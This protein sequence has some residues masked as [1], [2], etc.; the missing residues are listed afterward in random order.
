MA[1]VEGYVDD[2]GQALV[3]I[4]VGGSRGER[5]LKAV[6]DTGFSGDVSLPTSLA[7][8]LGLELWGAEMFELADGSRVEGLLFAGRLRLGEEEREVEVVL[9]N[10]PDALVGAGLLR[11][12][13]LEID[14]PSRQVI[15]R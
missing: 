5:V 15:I 10:S 3:E 1:V 4:G 12:K 6:V 13:R 9:S 2:Q 7:V 14:Y 11:G 8:Q